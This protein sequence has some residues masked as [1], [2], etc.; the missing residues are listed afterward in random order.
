MKTTTLRLP[1]NIYNEIW[2]IHSE[3]RKS[4]NTI[5]VELI[6]KGLEK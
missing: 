6:E 1:D 5:I 2:R 3:T 4:I